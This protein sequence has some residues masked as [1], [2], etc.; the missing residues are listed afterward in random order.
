MV[1]DGKVDNCQIGGCGGEAIGDPHYIVAAFTKEA[2][3]TVSDVQ[4]G[5]DPHARMVARS[6]ANHAPYRAA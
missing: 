4:V 2:D 1:G 5:D 6:V 3:S